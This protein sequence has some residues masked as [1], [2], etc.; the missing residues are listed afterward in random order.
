MDHH[1]QPSFSSIALVTINLQ[2]DALDGGPMESP[3]TTALLQKA[4]WLAEA[5]RRTQLPI[6]HMVRL[7]HRGGGNA[8]L[9]RRHRLESGE[10]IFA[11][12]TP[13]SEL[14]AELFSDNYTLLDPGVLLTGGVQ[15]I[16]TSE[17][18]LFQPRWGAFYQTAL[19]RQLRAFEV[20]TVAFIGADYANALRPSIYEASER[21]FRIVAPEDA[22]AG[23]DD[24]GRDE[25]RALGVNLMSAADLEEAVSGRRSADTTVS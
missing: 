10:A 9:C 11:P 20:T 16:G 6:Y 14:A 17:S 22:M 8:E 3:G 24:R 5:F 4:R 19:E 25:L 7:Y 13:G 12:G 23:L 18:I 2:R 15:R 21:D 1:T